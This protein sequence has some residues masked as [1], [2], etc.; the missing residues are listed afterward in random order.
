MKQIIHER[1]TRLQYRVQ[2]TA[3]LMLCLALGWPG[4]L[5]YPAGILFILAWGLLGR[6]LWQG[7]SI[8]RRFNV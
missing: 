4:W 5:V 8:Y 2:L 3:V 7:Y 1:Q 6:D